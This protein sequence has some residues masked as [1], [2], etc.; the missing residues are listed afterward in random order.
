[1]EWGYSRL[2]HLNLRQRDG[3]LELQ[4][5]D[6]GEILLNRRGVRLALADSQAELRERDGRIRHLENQLRE[7]GQP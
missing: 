1:M 5:P 7:L 3:R 6:T 4:D 2:L